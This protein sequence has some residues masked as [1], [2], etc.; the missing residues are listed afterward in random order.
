MTLK[1]LNDKHFTGPMGLISVGVISLVLIILLFGFTSL[2][3][4][5]RFMNSDLMQTGIPVWFI[6]L[7]VFIILI[8]NRNKKYSRR[9]Y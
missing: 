2:Y 8:I 4:F 6:L 7:V 3:Y 9:G 5:I 1:D